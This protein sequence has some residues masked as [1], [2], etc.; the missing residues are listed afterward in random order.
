MLV[1]LT[2]TGTN[3]SYAVAVAGPRFGPGASKVNLPLLCCVSSNKGLIVLVLILLRAVPGERELPAELE[4]AISGGMSRVVTT[5]VTVLE[6]KISSRWWIIS[7]SSKRLTLTKVATYRAQ[8]LDLT[9]E[10]L[11][12]IVWYALVV[13]DELREQLLVVTLPL[14]YAFQ[15]IWSSSSCPVRSL[16]RRSTSTFTSGSLELVSQAIGRCIPHLP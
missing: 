5:W 6:K 12:N 7:T 9:G 14:T 4:E 1:R 3:D 11:T 10:L 8:S 15:V 16:T 13:E 2:D